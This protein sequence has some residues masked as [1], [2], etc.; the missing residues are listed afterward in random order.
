MQTDGIG[1]L[2]WASKNIIYEVGDFA[3]G[4]IIFWVDET[5]QHGLV[6]AKEDQSTGIR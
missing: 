3:L 4:G 6:C 5:G 2:S 1:G